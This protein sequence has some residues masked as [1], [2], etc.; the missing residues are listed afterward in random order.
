MFNVS[1]GVVHISFVRAA[2]DARCETKTFR[3][4]YYHL[5]IHIDMFIS[6]AQSEYLNGLTIIE[7]VESVTH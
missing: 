7:V 6:A 2:N 4:M 1:N 3:S 5:H